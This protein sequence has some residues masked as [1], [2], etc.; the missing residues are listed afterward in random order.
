MDSALQQQSMLARDLA[1]AC[2]E[3]LAVVLK[4][5][6]PGVQI[7]QVACAVKACRQLRVTCDCNR[8]FLW[9]SF[10]YPLTRSSF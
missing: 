5:A 7:A 1:R 4:R 3:R 2:M 6:F 9:M 10:P 8:F